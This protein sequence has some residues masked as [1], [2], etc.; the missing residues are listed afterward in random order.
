[1][2]DFV[3]LRIILKINKEINVSSITFIEK[4][5]LK[6]TARIKRSVSLSLKPSWL[7]N[8]DKMRKLLFSHF[9]E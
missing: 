2:I 5:Y 9:K 3:Y 7:T 1:M 4:I 6:L 8:R